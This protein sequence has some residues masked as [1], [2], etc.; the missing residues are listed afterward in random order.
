MTP[1][2]QPPSQR[3]HATGQRPSG[4]VSPLDPATD[5]VVRS[6]WSELAERHG[7]REAARLVPMPHLSYQVAAE[8]DHARAGAVVAALAGATSAFAVRITGIAVFRAPEPVLFLAVERSAALDALHLALW[9]RLVEDGAA[10]AAARDASPLYGPASWRPHIT[11]AQKDLT[12]A[13]LDDMLSA[14]SGRDL[15]RE[16]W[17]DT[18]A[19]LHHPDGGDVA[20]VALRSPLRRADR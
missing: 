20:E 11:L 4:I 5:H 6:L 16:V 17:I 12:L 13:Q 7:L 15:Q 1:P 2:S 3:P 19:L 9:E 10:Q 18:L 14:W 8:Y